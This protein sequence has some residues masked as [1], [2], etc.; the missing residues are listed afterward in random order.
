MSATI[1]EQS[2]LPSALHCY[3]WRVIKLQKALLKA[4]AALLFMLR[5]PVTVSLMEQVVHLQ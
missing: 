2:V 4:V 5:S 1:M 3:S